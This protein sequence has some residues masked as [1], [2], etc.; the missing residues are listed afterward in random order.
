MFHENSMK[1]KQDE[2]H[3]LTSFGI[4]TTCLLP[5]C[6]LENS[7][8]QKYIFVKIGRKLNFNKH[9]TNQCVYQAENSITCKNFPI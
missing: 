4:G 6:L 8:S 5:A 1:A 3:F 9:I 2:C 7:A